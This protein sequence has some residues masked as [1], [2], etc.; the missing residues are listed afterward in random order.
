M[1]WWLLAC[2]ARDP[3]PRTWDVDDTDK[4][5]QELVRAFLDVGNCDKALDTVSA[6]R[7]HGL[8]SMELDLLQA[9]AL[10]CKGLPRD[11]LTLLNGR[12]RNVSRRN[13]LACLANAD[14]GQVED[15]VPECRMA[16][17]NL[18]R[19]ASRREQAEAWQNLGF[20]LAADGQHDEAVDAYQQALLL[21][22]TYGRARNNLA[23]SLVALDRDNEALDTFRV[24]LQEQYADNPSLLEAN[25]HYN[26]GL[27]QETRGD[28]DQARRSY[29]SALT[30][31][32][33]HPLA[34][35]ALDGLSPNK[36]AP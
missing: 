34:L 1:I 23:F 15:A 35:A 5:H 25:A 30:T 24:A 19:D 29:R 8:D 11:A 6:A 3:L 31:A 10:L 12:Y 14:L 28:E 21:E 2:A 7:D 26:L 16:V 27:A 20:V 9:E 22:P 33:D 13:A 4:V 32:P 17:R 36:E 18:P